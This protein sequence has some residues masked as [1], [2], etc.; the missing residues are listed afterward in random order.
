MATLSRKDKQ[1]ILSQVSCWEGTDPN[2]WLDEAGHIDHL[3][4][5][6][7]IDCMVCGSTLHYSK[8]RWTCGSC[9]TVWSVEELLECINQGIDRMIEERRIHEV[10]SDNLQG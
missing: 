6:A 1:Y 7:S 2:L 8:D 10:S 5:L 3:T 4:I 9:G